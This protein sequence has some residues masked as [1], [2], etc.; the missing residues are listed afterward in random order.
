MHKHAMK[1][2]PLR[3]KTLLHNTP[4]EL[5]HGCIG[6]LQCKRVD[7]GSA[8]GNMGMSF[9]MLLLGRGAS[10]SWWRRARDARVMKPCCAQVAMG[11]MPLYAALP[12]VTE[13]VVE[14]GWTRVYSRIADVGAPRYLAYFAVYMACVELGVYWMHRGLHDVRLGYRRARGGPLAPQCWRL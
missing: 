7:A 4:C 14:A 10:G 6:L 12:A 8:G 9:W 1:R 5:H 11:S 2:V 13:A 3:L